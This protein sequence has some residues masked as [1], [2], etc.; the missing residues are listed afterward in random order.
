MEE[1]VMEE[2]PGPYIPKEDQQ[3]GHVQNK[4]FMVFEQHVSYMSDPAAVDDI[5]YDIN[6]NAQPHLN[7]ETFMSCTKELHG[8]VDSEKAKGEVNIMGYKDWIQDTQVTAEENVLPCCWRSLGS[9]PESLFGQDVEHENTLS[10]S[11][12]CAFVPIQIKA[13]PLSSEDSSYDSDTDS[14]TSSSSSPATTSTT[15]AS[16]VSLTALLLDGD[17]DDDLTGRDGKGF[18]VTPKEVLHL[19]E[20]PAVEDLNITLPN[21]VE[22]KPCGV[23][24]STVDQLV[25]FESRFNQH[26]LGEGTIIFNEDKLPVGKIFEI[27]GPIPRPSYVL[28]FNSAQHIAEHGIKVNDIMYFVPDSEEFSKYL[29]TEKLRHG[30]GSDASWKNDEEPPPDD[31]LR[32][33]E[34]GIVN[35]PLL[36]RKQP[37]TVLVS[38][39]RNSLKIH[40]GNSD[41][42]EIQM[43]HNKTLIHNGH[44]LKCSLQ[45]LGNR[46][47]IHFQ[48]ITGNKIL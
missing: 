34:C 30:K 45:T 10:S 25:I 9:K 43:I 19:N 15:T 47:L 28:R 41:S 48:H 11:I 7:V 13:E 39:R 44:L 32:S 36:H 20:L 14:D 40:K 18:P 8:N 29:E 26:V 1:C 22:V 38:R 37:T 12:N 46:S 3:D 31:I 33:M 16:S 27:F 24:T 2:N 42:P 4:E 6:S 35:R 17:E 5:T 23:V 21:D